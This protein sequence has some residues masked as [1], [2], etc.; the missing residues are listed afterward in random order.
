MGSEKA[1]HKSSSYGGG[2][3]LRHYYPLGSRFYLFG[4]GSLGVNFTNGERKDSTALVWE[5]KI[6]VISLSLTP[7]ISFAASKRLHLEAALNSLVSMSYSFA[8]TTY[9]YSGSSTT[10]ISHRSFNVGAN[11]NGFSRLS[12]G[13]RWILPSKG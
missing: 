12:I 4:D 2:I 6:T 5:D 11:A 10:K 3:F 8:E 7:G 9:T 1:I 13:L